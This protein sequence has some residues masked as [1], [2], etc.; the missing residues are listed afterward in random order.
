M[1]HYTMLSRIPPLNRQVFFCFIAYRL[2]D[3]MALLIVISSVKWA[4]GMHR[5]NK[6][7]VFFKKLKF[8]IEKSA[9]LMIH[10][11]IVLKRLF[12]VK[13]FPFSSNINIRGVVLSVKKDSYSRPPQFI[14]R[15]PKI[16]KVFKDLKKVATKDI[17]VLV[18]GEQGTYK[19]LIAHAIHVHS[20]RA[21]GPFLTA[22]LPPV[23]RDSVAAELF[24]NEK[25]TPKGTTERKVGKIEAA[26]KGTLFIEDISALD[27]KIQEDLLRLIH[28]KEFRPINSNKS[29][30]SDV[31]VIVG[32]TRRVKD[33]LAKDQI[34]GET[35]K[36]GGGET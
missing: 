13:L 33:S 2:S 6:N 18:S 7:F 12:V 4:R 31:R 26:N 34:L 22:N 35:Y 21:K 14:G 32:T 16:L 28:E 17:P 23:S 24:G 5:F 9:H 30:K 20:A 36:A 1:Y 19:D 11:L 10:S 25:T 29:Y 15:S 8:F 27:I 3:K